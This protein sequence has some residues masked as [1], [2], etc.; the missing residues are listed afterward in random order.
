MQPWD[1]PP[2]REARS[3]RIEAAVLVAIVV[4]IVL[5]NLWAWGR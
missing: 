3:I 5:V 1:E 4:F 2:D